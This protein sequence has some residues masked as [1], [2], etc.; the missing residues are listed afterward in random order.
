MQK[1]RVMALGLAGLMVMSMAG[2]GGS[3]APAATESGATE[4]GASSD[5]LQVVI[6]DNNQRK[7]LQEIADEFTKETGIKVAIEVK[8]WNTYWQLLQSG[9]TGGDMPDVFWMHSNNSQMYMKNDM[10]LDLTDYIANSDKIDM[11]NYMEGIGEL[12]TREN[13]VY[14]IPKDYDTIALWYNKTMFDE[15]GI[16]YPNETWTW[17]TV[18]EAAQKL[19]KE[20]GSQFGFGVNTGNN[21][22]TYYNMIYANG[23]FVVNDDHTASG[24]DDPKTIEAMEYVGQLLQYAPSQATMSETGVD[25]LMESG[26]IAMCTQGSW[27]LPGFMENDYMV[28]NCD[29]AIIPYND[30]TNLRASCINGLG[31]A[32]AANTKRPED[33]WKLI[34]WFGSEEM[35]KKQA[36]LG[37]TMSAF[38]GTSEDWI[39]ST[40]KF[41]LNAYMDVTKPQDDNGVTNE[42]VLRP[43][44][45]N[46]EE[47]ENYV[48]QTFVDGWN[49]PSTMADVCKG[50]AEHVNELI[51]QENK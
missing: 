37:V 44:T 23:G 12:Y 8:E 30:A 32:A 34:E 47:W 38:N 3:A 5:A 27:M 35:Q 36:E 40:D 26:Q 21:Q 43:Y 10:L 1:R 25:V 42:L 17:N 28:E 45:Y 48:T 15:A 24:Y 14:A 9:A 16:D 18:L 7:G 2:C 22:D 31:W 33:C 19:T 4:G 49:D 11:S 39:N 29:V 20:D 50:I 13:K 46:T 51:S 41:N 6:W